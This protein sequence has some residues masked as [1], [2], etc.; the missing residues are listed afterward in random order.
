MTRQKETALH[1]AVKCSQF[2]A[3][4][5][6]VHRIRELNKE[7]VFNMKDEQGNT[8]LHLATWR[9]QRKVNVVSCSLASLFLIKKFK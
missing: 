6:L 2:E 7:D 8:V 1:L 5:V 4:S 9:K 3:A